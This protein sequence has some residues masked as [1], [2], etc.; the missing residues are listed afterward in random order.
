MLE[1][2]VTLS[3]VPLKTIAKIERQEALDNFNK[4][5]KEVDGIMVARGDLGIEVNAEQ[6]PLHQ[7]HMIELCLA[8]AKPVIVATQML[9]S[10]IDNWCLP[11]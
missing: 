11:I 6:V 3:L 10:M 1:C 5:L 2:K 8:A 9:N 4:I 7:K